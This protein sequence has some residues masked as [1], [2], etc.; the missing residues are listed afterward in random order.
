MGQCSNSYPMAIW[1]HILFFRN[2]KVNLP[3]IFYQYSKF[4]TGKQT[5][6]QGSLSLRNDEWNQAFLRLI[7]TVYFKKNMEQGLT[8][9]HLKI[10]SRASSHLQELLMPH[11]FNGWKT[12]GKQS[13]LVSQMRTKQWEIL[14]STAT[15][16][17][18]EG[19]QCLHC[20]NLPSKISTSWPCRIFP[21]DWVF[22]RGAGRER[23]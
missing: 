12:S 9:T 3:E 13:G 19:C 20:F 15:Q 22:S 7:G 4:I 17:C 2:R 21:I 16:S 10:T 5:F 6:T 18:S 23:K 11:I 8:P 1:L 14:P